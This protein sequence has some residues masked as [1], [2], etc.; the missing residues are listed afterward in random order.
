MPDER[1]PLERVATALGFRPRAGGVLQPAQ[2]AAWE[3]FKEVVAELGGA[4]PA[5]PARPPPGP[6]EH[7]DDDMAI[8][9]PPKPNQ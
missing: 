5:A 4:F 3:R 7:L 9:L 2:Q 1:D 6:F 8:W